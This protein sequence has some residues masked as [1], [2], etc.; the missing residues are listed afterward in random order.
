MES[1][2]ERRGMPVSTDLH[3]RGRLEQGPLGLILR[4]DGGGTWELDAGP[5]ARRLVGRQVEVV[6]QR[7]GFN[8]V[9]CEQ[10]WLPGGPRPRQT[11]I[12]IEYVLA[13]GLAAYGFIA[14]LMGLASYFR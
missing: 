14:F 3:L 4:A 12:R 1:L 7:A 8:A 9:A 10:V 5:R 11:K 13:G 6:G 2:L